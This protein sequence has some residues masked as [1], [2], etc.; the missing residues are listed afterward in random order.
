[1]TSLQPSVLSL[2]S[3]LKQNASNEP[4]DVQASFHLTFDL[5]VDIKV[6]NVLFLIGGEIGNVYGS[7]VAAAVWLQFGFGRTR[8][9]HCQLASLGIAKIN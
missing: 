9:G 8:V 3:K 7:A 2:P 6:A 5:V 1:M 4:A